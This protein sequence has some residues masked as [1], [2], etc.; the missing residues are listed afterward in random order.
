MIA[1][2]NRHL[3]ADHGL[4]LPEII[5]GDYIMLE[6][7]G[8]GIGMPPEMKAKIFDPF[9][10]TKQRDTGTG[11][12]LSMVFGFMKQSDGHVHVYS[13]VGVG[14]VFRHYL[15]RA[16]GAATQAEMFGCARR[17]MPRPR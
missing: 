9:F 14:T 1:A 6:V 3:D 5:P 2:G 15:P 13:E 4:G 8:N 12:G 11:L 17:A 16:S 7:G 10:T